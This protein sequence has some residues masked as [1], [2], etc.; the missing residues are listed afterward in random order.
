MFKYYLEISE[1]LR[2]S[3]GVGNSRFGCTKIQ[4]SREM[5]KDSIRF[6]ERRDREILDSADQGVRA[7]ILEVSN[8]PGNP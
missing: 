8:P 5:M 4:D 1:K 7:K 6:F 2:K 3:R